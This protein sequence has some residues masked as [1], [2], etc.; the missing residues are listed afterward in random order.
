M[1][2]VLPESLRVRLAWHETLPNHGPESLALVDKASPSTRLGSPAGKPSGN[3]VSRQQIAAA[4]M[5]PLNGSGC[6]A[7]HPSADGCRPFLTRRARAALLPLLVLGACAQTNPLGVA[8]LPQ[9]TANL[10]RTPRVSGSVGRPSQLPP[11]Q[12]AYGTTTPRPTTVGAPGVREE[13]GGNISLDFVDT[14]IREV[15]AQI[16]GNA[17][18]LNYSID[19][20]VK[21]TATFRTAR[22]LPRSRL[23]P[24]LQV[25]LAQNGAAMVAANGLYRITQTGEATTAAVSAGD[26]SAGGVVLRLRFASAEPLAKLLTPFAGSLAKI[27]AEPG[28]NALLISGDPAARDAL[29]ALAR[30][31]D[32][33]A[34]AGQSYALLPVPSGSAKDFASAMEA[35][36]K[37]G[38]GGA[39][40]GL[41]RIVPLERLG[42]VLII[43]HEPRYIDEARRVF[44]LVARGH[45]F[46]ERS[47]HVYYLQ[48]SHSDDM[49]YLLQQAFTPNRVTAQPTQAGQASR[50]GPGQFN[51]A[52]GIGQG[53]GFGGYGTGQGGGFGGNGIGQGGG[54]GPGGGFGQGSF[55]QG[56]FV[57]AASGMGPPGYGPGGGGQPPGSDPSG[58]GH[59]PGTASANPLLGGLDTTG[60][61]NE[62]GAEGMRI[63]PNTQNNAVLVY[64]TP[65]EASSVE[66]MLR[67]VDILPLQV[68][69][70]A[71][72]AEVTLTDQLQYGTQFMFQGSS[73]VPAL[74]AASSGGITASVFSGK[75]IKEILGALQKIT[76]VD[77]LSSP[78]LLV[79]DNETAHLMVGAAVPYLAQTA[80][81]TLTSNA[82]IVN[83]VQY[84]QTGVLMDVTPRVNS[85]GLVTLDV[86]QEVSDVA[87]DVTTTGLNSPT[88]NERRVLSRVVV[89]DGQ[90]VG[91]AGLIQ[92]S[93][94]KSNGGVPWFKDIPIL[95]FFVSQQDNERN[96]TELLVLITPHVIHDQRDAR[97]FT[98]D[99]REQLPSAAVVPQLSRTLPA[100]GSPDPLAHLRRRGGL[101]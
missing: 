81:S 45:R 21:G 15:V 88:F 20:S 64:A 6:A 66:A 76:T 28:S 2:I 18:H 38:T 77:V 41:V 84:Q 70:D 50:A 12:F 49:A 30:N 8:P 62:T 33:E 73:I 40:A 89:Q 61:G 31:F 85:G 35:T 92:D 65:Q 63:V 71:V 86:S 46:S 29:A 23:L 55:S 53:G 24:T 36:F 56:G 1:R 93:V 26:T 69:I 94:N 47:W 51:G 98:E 32:T 27:A 4:P 59:P 67:K 99:L 52:G 68:R 54:F 34:L 13:V 83:S 37:S 14:D 57:G 25:L 22:P 91:L 5:T 79:V 16:L 3:T 7:G 74:A 17:L 80:Q 58:A 39:L 19:P 90:T 60:T 42:S 87:A 95:S 9:T 48:N 97:A 82:P 75:G 44:S 11:A 78:D 10:E 72:I 100:T 101:Q 43:A 96:K